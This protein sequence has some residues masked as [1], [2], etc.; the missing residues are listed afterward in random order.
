MSNNGINFDVSISMGKFLT[1]GVVGQG[2]RAG[3]SGGK[4][5]LAA[6]AGALGGILGDRAANMEKMMA[7]LDGLNAES[8]KLTEASK[9]DPKDE[10]VKADLQQNS[11]EF[12]LALTEFQA[13]SQMFSILSNATS[14]ALKSIGE[15]ITAVAR[16]Q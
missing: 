3:A 14:T 2:E 4:G 8:D 12:Q 11:R 7:K 10:G 16:K 13:E 1:D 5:W 9:N 6:L 15:G